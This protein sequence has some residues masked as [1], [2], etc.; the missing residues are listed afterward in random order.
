MY[1]KVELIAKI[2]HPL[3]PPAGGF[4]E[5]VLLIQK[6]GVETESIYTAS[7][8]VPLFLLNYKWFG[9]SIFNT[10]AI[11]ISIDKYCN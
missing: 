5:C 2:E 9:Y 10:E 8:R 11:E 1:R 3:N 7:K 6:Y 4:R